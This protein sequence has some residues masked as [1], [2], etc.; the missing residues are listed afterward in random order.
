MDIDSTVDKTALL[1]VMTIL[2]AAYSWSQ[3]FA[4]VMSYGAIMTMTQGSGI[5]GFVL[6]MATCFKPHWAPYTTPLYALA[7]GLMLGGMSAFMEVQYPGL[8]I[9]TLCLTFGTLFSL[10]FAFRSRLIVVTQDFRSTV[11]TATGGFCVGMLGMMALRMFGVAV[12]FMYK[13]PVSIA[14][15]GVAVALAA[16][17]LLLDFDAIQQRAWSGAP[18]WMEWYSGFSMLVS[19]VWMYTSLLRLGAQMR[20]L[21]NSRD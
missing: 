8:V 17:N 18:K 6:A 21:G 5:A 12:P 4:G 11:Y 9:Q 2:S 20:G 13:G 14:V 3:I 7:K 10:L 16:S 15:S 19:L 1:L